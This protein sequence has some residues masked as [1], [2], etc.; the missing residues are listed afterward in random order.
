[1]SK[2]K[3][4]I[5]GA[6]LAGSGFAGNSQPLNFSQYGNYYQAGFR[7]CSELEQSMVATALANY[8]HNT[9]SCVWMKNRTNAQVFT[10]EVEN[11]SGLIRASADVKIYDG[12]T[13]DIFDVGASG[14]FSGD[15]RTI[16][17][18]MTGTSYDYTQACNRANVTIGVIAVSCAMDANCRN[19]N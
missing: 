3:T 9:D 2:L 15:G 8:V 12:F 11:Q 6:V 13:S 17:A 10:C 7:S 1:M 4:I 14:L 16:N 19:G 5:I 18:G